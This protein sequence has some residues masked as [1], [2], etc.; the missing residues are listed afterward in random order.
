MTQSCCQDGSL[1]VNWAPGHSLEADRHYGETGV[2]WSMSVDPE[3]NAQY[4]INDDS[5]IDPATGFKG[6]QSW[7]DGI[8]AAN[9]KLQ[10]RSS[11]PVWLLLHIRM[12][13][14]IVDALSELF[15]GERDLQL[16]NGDVLHL[17][18]NVVLVFMVDELMLPE[19]NPNFSQQ[20]GVVNFETNDNGA[21]CM[22]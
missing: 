11:V 8:L 5:K 12:D 3:G 15:G 18:E 7:R 22:Q 21:C 1:I 16:Q 10:A 20:V 14:L 6:K 13:N 9:L 2:A 4:L 19:L 17:P